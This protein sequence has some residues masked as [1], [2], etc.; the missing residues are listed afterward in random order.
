MSLSR[1]GL[2]LVM[3]SLEIILYTTLHKLMGLKW[4][5]NV[6]LVIFGMSTIKELFTSLHIEPF[7]K[8]EVTALTTSFPMVGHIFL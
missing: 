8:K 1:R 3:R 6:G 7:R 4:L 2:S 5:T